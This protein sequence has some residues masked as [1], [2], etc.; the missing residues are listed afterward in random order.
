MLRALMGLGWVADLVD[1]CGLA[2]MV[3]MYFRVGCA[4]DDSR[5]KYF[6]GSLW[7]M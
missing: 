2:A 6:G 3:R 5:I 4:F 7:Q 1:F